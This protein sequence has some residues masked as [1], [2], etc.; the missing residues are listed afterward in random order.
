MSR[1]TATG[2]LPTRVTW[3]LGSAAVV[4]AVTVSEYLGTGSTG[5]VVATP[6]LMFGLGLAYE[7]VSS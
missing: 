7:L 1:E 2:R 3:V 6:V 5:A 4:L